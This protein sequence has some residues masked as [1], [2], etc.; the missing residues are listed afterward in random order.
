VSIGIDGV[1]F[2]NVPRLQVQHRRSDSIVV[3]EFAQLEL[4]SNDVRFLNECR[5]RRRGKDR[6]NQR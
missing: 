6:Q 4:V 5:E 1:G 2:E 3:P